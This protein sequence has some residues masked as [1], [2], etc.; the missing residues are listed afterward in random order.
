MGEL[1]RIPDSDRPL[2]P[3]SGSPINYAHAEVNAILDMI[4]NK[5]D[6]NEDDEF[7][8]PAITEV[9]NLIKDRRSIYMY[10]H[11]DTTGFP[12]LGELIYIESYYFKCHTCGCIL[13]TNKV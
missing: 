7:T 3:N 11:K 1:I 4:W 13:P 5:F 8:N 2:C 12:L 6:K 10:L 9:W